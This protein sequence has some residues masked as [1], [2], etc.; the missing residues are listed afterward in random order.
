M[1]AFS[2]W[3]TIFVL[4]AICL[5][6][7]IVAVDLAEQAA[8]AA[9]EAREGIST[10]MQQTETMK[11]WMEQAVESMRDKFQEFAETAQEH[12][13]DFVENVRYV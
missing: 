11:T 5:S 13:Q 4:A 2:F 6:P 12:F 8:A 9:D 7:L 1:A 3:L 10:L